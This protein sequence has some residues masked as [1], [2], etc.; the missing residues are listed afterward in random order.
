MVNLDMSKYSIVTL[1]EVHSTNGYALE[2]MRFLDDKTVIYT[3]HQSS[4]RGR[5]NRKWL[6]DDSGNIYM[7]I[8]LK[9][10]EINEYPFPNLTQYLSV[11]LCNILQKDFNFNPVIKWPNDILVNQ[12]KIS[13]ILAESYMENNSIKGVVLGLGLNV[14]LKQET[15]DKID[16]KATSI[17]VLKNKYF[18]CDKIIR[19]ICDEFF[20]G[21]EQFVKNGF[22]YIKDEY[23]QRCFFIGQNIRI[24]EN[25]EKKEYFAESIDDNGF[26]TVKNEFGNRSKII[27]G[28][29]QC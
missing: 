20:D 25:G 9:P 18:D 24:S 23:I 10:D 1:D 5:Y 2:N 17:S 22:P 29:L 19:R 16:Q 11:V 12:C 3:Q 15:I 21:Y 7:S 13:G 4:G 27:T 14:N 8:V 6:G 26:L 28:D